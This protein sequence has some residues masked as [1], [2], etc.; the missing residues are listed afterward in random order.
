[1]STSYESDVYDLLDQAAELEPCSTK[2][3]LLEQAVAM[4]DAHQDVDLGFRV[5]KKLIYAAAF[6]GYPEKELVAF[7]WCLAQ[8]DRQPDQFEE[9]EL[10]WEYKWIIGSLPGFVTITRQQMEEMIADMQRRY[11]RAG[12][13]LHAVYKVQ[14]SV[15]E[16]CGD[17]QAAARYH[18]L[19]QKTKPDGRSDCSAC[20]I[21]AEA[22]YL[23]FQEQD[24]KALKKVAKILRGQLSC[25]TVPDRTYAKLAFPLVRL[26]RA[27]EALE[28]YR[29]SYKTIHGNRNFFWSVSQYLGLMVLTENMG[30]AVKLFQKHLPW[31]LET[32]SDS[33][34]FEFL[35]MASFLFDRLVAA[36][37][38]EVKLRLPK[39]FPLYQEEGTYS[40]PHIADWLTKQLTSLAARFDTRN[41]NSYDSNR[42]KEKEQWTKLIAKVPLR[43]RKKKEE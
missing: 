4:A 9:T 38:K 7:S 12:A 16:S 11:E 36:G 41:G 21:D 39:E 42:I 26:G 19:L 8:C 32:R 10:L 40:V 5:R 2:V 35:L 22:D 17:K 23:I 33:S 3:M 31:A 34:R 13:S 29:Q 18:E 30:E 20:V 6:S 14:R 37:K 43:P 28:Y 15:A 27:A 1:M 24:A 25:M